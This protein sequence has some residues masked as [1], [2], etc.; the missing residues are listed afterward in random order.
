MDNSNSRPE[1]PAPRRN[2]Q[3]EATAGTPFFGRAFGYPASSSAT[4][5]SLP[6]SEEAAETPIQ[7]ARMPTSLEVRPSR[8]SSI[9][10]TITN[11]T[12]ATLQ[13]DD[14]STRSARSID[15]MLGGR[16]FHINRDGSK[17]SSSSDNDLPPY[18]PS[19]PTYAQSSNH[20]D[21][22][23]RNGPQPPELVT[24]T[25]RTPSPLAAPAPKSRIHIPFWTDRSRHRRLSS[26]TSQSNT[27]PALGRL[28]SNSMFDLSKLPS[29]SL[30]N[31]ESQPMEENGVYRSPWVITG[32][33]RI[34]IVSK[35]RSASQGNIPESVHSWYE[36]KDPKHHLRRRN[37]IRLPRLFTSLTNIKFGSTSD[38]DQDPPSPSSRIIQS[39]GPSCGTYQR[40]YA[41]SPVFTARSS[42]SGY[43]TPS[44]STHLSPED[45][46]PQRRPSLPNIPMLSLAVPQ[47]PVKVEEGHVD[48][49][50]PPPM[51]D[52]N[53]VSIHYT[54]L[55]RSID[56][57]HRKALHARDK[58]LAGM[59][60]RLNEIDQVYRQELKSRDFTIDDMRKRLENLQEQMNGSIERAKNEV[61]DMWEARWKH[62][63]RHLMERMRRIELETQIQV[64]KAVAEHDQEWVA[65]WEKRNNELLERLRVA[66]G[67]AAGQRT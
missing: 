11:S 34:S 55:I 24:S 50:P 49:E 10:S 26:S 7:A 27:K 35:G 32:P 38:Q 17:I 63:D 42:T 21:T 40:K 33:E 12:I 30:S 29:A 46:A 53:D 3:Q 54:R 36:N 45:G 23:F 52:E 43:P 2:T 8:A 22:S 57:D 20:V 66:E 61:E 51:E 19:L 67:G 64:E 31:P 9:V 1:T 14:R 48:I 4:T 65:E 41:Q 6:G 44:Y 18:S 37:G 13:D 62:R 56:R 59:R 25:A 47:S 5:P 15:L 39:A 16:L 28:N 60:E 58:E